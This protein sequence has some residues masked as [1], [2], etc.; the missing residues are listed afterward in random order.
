MFYQF[1]FDIFESRDFI[2]SDIDVIKR[3]S[4]CFCFTGSFSYGTRDNMKNYVEDRGS[5]FSKLVTIKVNYLVVGTKENSTWKHG[6]HGNKI[7]NA[8]NLK[9]KGYDIKIVSENKFFKMY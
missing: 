2:D 9:Q 6:S 8:I 7:E 4:S 3:D 5:V 1:E